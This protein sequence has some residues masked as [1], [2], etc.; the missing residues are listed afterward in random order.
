MAKRMSD[1]TPAG[2]YGSAKI[3]VL[4]VG[5]YDDVMCMSRSELK[6]QASKQQKGT[7]SPDQTMVQ[8]DMQALS[9]KPTYLCSFEREVIK[10]WQLKIETLRLLRKGSVLH[11]SFVNVPWEK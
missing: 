10:S 5:G 2:T 7:I 1:M 4:Y 11:V 3:L 9:S 8:Q 6:K